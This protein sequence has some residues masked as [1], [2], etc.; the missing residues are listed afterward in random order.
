MKRLPES[1]EILILWVVIM[2][3]LIAFGVHRGNQSVK[4]PIN[5]G[6]CQ[7][8]VIQG[9]SVKA[10]VPP[11]FLKPVILGTVV[12]EDIAFEALLDCLSFYE[13]SHNPRAV[14]EI[15]ECGILQFRPAT[16]QKYCIEKYGLPND[17]WD[18]NTQYV[19]ADKML[20]ESFDNR[21]HWT[22]INKCQRSQN[23]Y[24]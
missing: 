11:Y 9:N 13:S 5:Y 6:V 8:V 24:P 10:I 1:I 16:F 12:H 20:R 4:E 17:I 3:G 23:N 22:T 2:L 19:C 21:F 7:S 14:G 18:A 15:D